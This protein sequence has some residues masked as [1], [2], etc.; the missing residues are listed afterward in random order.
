MLTEND[1]CV[2]SLCNVTNNNSVRGSTRDVE[3]GWVNF[4]FSKKKEEK[5]DLLEGDTKL[6]SGGGGEETG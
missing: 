2:A 6:M 1:I 4:N 3:K 5:I